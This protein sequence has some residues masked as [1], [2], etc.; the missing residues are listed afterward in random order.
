MKF[1]Q[2]KIQ[3]F[4]ASCKG[5]LVSERISFRH[6]SISKNFPERNR[7]IAGLSQVVVVVESKERGGSLITAELAL[8]K[9]ETS[10]P[11]LETLT[12]LVPEVA[13]S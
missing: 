13:I 7:I 12:V 6:E 8:K 4:E 1:T 3:I 5:G 10:M 11:F 9:I 2:N